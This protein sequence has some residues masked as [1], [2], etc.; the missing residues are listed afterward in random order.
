MHRG[1]ILTIASL[2][3]LAG[4]LAPNRAE[5][6]PLLDW[7]F[8]RHRMQPAYTVGA[9]VPVGNGMGAY[10]AGYAPY[11]NYNPYA[12]T[13]P[14]AASYAAAYPNNAAAGNYGTYYGSNLPV[15]GPQGAAYPATMPSGIAASTLPSTIPNG[16]YSYVP[17]YSTYANRTPVTYYRPLLTT[18]PNTGAQVVAMAPC[19][20]YEYQTQ[21]LPTF[22]RSALYGSYPAPS[23]PL[24]PQSTLPTYTLPSGGIPLANNGVMPQTVRGFAP[25]S[26][27]PG[28]APY[29]TVP[30]TGVY[31]TAPLGTSSYYGSTY[32]SNYGSGYGS[33]GG[34]N[35]MGGVLPGAVYPGQTYPGQTYPGQ[36]YQGGTVP[37]LVA[38]Q[39][40]FQ[41]SAPGL[42]TPGLS[43]PGFVPPSS[44]PA[45][46]VPP[47]LP[48]SFPSQN[49]PTSSTRTE[50]PQ[51]QRITQQPAERSRLRSYSNEATGTNSDTESPDSMY[52][53]DSSSPAATLKPIPVPD[54]FEPSRW[55]PGLLNE[56]DLTAMAPASNRGQIAGPAQLAGP[57]QLAGMSTTIHWAS[58]EQP[59]PQ[60]T[61]ELELSPSARQLRRVAMDGPIES[62]GERSEYVEPARGS[63]APAWVPQPAPQRIQQPSPA[64]APTKSAPVGSRYDNS[65]WRAVPAGRR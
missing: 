35:A 14:Y 34:T 64:S 25:Y 43:T 31:P 27:V 39:P 21:R 23:I 7:L 48:P 29:A 61:G 60:A 1:L 51:L 17:N 37:G 11:G 3:M 63:V 26:T 30:N 65:G 36:G 53:S 5:A 57:T 54:G 45:A 49:F 8:G 2:T 38:P 9:P 24:P 40:S 20:S 41:P 15:L 42:S 56:D 44:D 33:C 55:N 18:D 59:T 32:G 50:R 13:N 28:A 4:S 6:G 16:T 47:T 62:A 19:T 10:G 52:R 58:F 46:N 12:N 22:G